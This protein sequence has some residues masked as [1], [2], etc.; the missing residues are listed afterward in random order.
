MRK[1][2]I[3]DIPEAKT[4]EGTV[5]EMHGELP[6]VQ[7]PEPT[8]VQEE[9]PEREKQGPTEQTM[10]VVV[11]VAKEGEVVKEEAVAAEHEVKEATTPPEEAQPEAQQ[12]CQK[13]EEAERVPQPIQEETQMDCTEAQLYTE[14]EAQVVQADTVNSAS[15]PIPTTQPSKGEPV[16][17]TP[18]PL[19]TV[20]EREQF[21]AEPEKPEYHTEPTPVVSKEE[22]VPVIDQSNTPMDSMPFQLPC[23]PTP[24]VGVSLNVE[25]QFSEPLPTV[26]ANVIPFSDLQLIKEEPEKPLS[27][28][29]K[30]MFDESMYE[31]E[32]IAVVDHLHTSPDQCFEKGD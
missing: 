10:D 29:R 7:Q 19:D 1:D 21:F 30:A 15:E 25:D 32:V 28:K 23:L 5:A 3:R 27:R 31:E 6:E 12:E 14:A 20:P 17:P 9:T 4:Q 8:T 22:Y 26:S 13:A 18:L 11:E 16:E 24:Q 2:R